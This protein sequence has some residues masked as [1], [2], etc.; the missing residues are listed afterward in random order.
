MF[1]TTIPNFNPPTPPQ[2]PQCHFVWRQVGFALRIFK[3]KKFH[4]PRSAAISLCVRELFMVTNRDDVL[5]THQLV[6]VW[7]R[8]STQPLQNDIQHATKT[9]LSASSPPTMCLL[10][11]WKAYGECLYATLF[12]ECGGGGGWKNLAHNE[13]VFCLFCFVFFLMFLLRSCVFIRV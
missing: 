13:M 11:K 7:G 12:N 6:L 1:W 10:Q 2:P 5:H 4:A 8:E 9:Q 3:E